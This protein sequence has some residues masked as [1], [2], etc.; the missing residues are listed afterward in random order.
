MGSREE[1]EEGQYLGAEEE[2]ESGLWSE[3]SSRCS[4]KYRGLCLQILKKEDSS[5]DL[6]RGRLRGFVPRASL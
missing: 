2:E 1:S 5:S 6:S 3:P 4:E